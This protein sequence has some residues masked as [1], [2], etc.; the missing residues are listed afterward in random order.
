MISWSIAEC[1][2]VWVVVA[3]ILVWSQWRWGGASCGLPFA[4][5]IG[6]AIIH[7]PGAVLYLDPDSDRRRAVCLLVP[8]AFERV[9]G[10]ALDGVCAVSRA[11]PA[12]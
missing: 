2:A 9:S 7:V 8:A 10:E 5:V 1:L 11:P 3:V 12:A 4:Y 6:L